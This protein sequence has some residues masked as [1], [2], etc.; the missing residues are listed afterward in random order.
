MR[1]AGSTLRRGRRTGRGAGRGCR[2]VDDRLRRSEA[3]TTAAPALSR[4]S[5]L[6]PRRRRAPAE[7]PKPILLWRPARFEQRPRH[8]HGP[9]PATRAPTAAARRRTSERRRRRAA[10]PA[11]PPHQ[12]RRDRRQRPRRRQAEIQPR[13]LQ[14]SAEAAGRRR[15]PD[16]QRQ[17]PRARRTAGPSPRR[18]GAEAGL[19]AASRARSGRSQ[20]DPDV[21]L[22][23]ARRAARPAKK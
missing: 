20:V 5:R 1:C 22:R 7:E 19:P 18:D 3:R 9:P 4:R 15:R 10:T 11:R 16:P 14:G 6:R 8:R 13:P 17:P 2:A 21:A 12:G 23:Q